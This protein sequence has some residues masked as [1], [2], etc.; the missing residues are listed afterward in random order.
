MISTKKYESKNK[1]YIKNRDSIKQYNKEYY[2]NNRKYYLEYRKKKLQ[3]ERVKNTLDGF[4]IGN[5]YKIYS[6][7]NP[8]EIYIGS[9]ILPIKQRLDIHKGMYKRYKEGLR[10]NNTSFNIFAKNPLDTIYI[11]SLGE[12]N[13]LNN[14]HLHT[15]EQLWM[16]KYKSKILNK[17]FSYSK[18]NNCIKNHLKRFKNDIYN[19]AANMYVDSVFNTRSILD[20]WIC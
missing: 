11:E 8:N 6:T 19:T 16:N 2:D 3:S 17:Y 18:L 20:Q 1:L 13:V 14:E 5:V 9:T 4:V 15:Y 10:G 12:Y 7:N